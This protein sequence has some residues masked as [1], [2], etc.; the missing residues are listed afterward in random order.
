MN[1][2]IGP[3]VLDDNLPTIVDIIKSFGDKIEVIEDQLFENIDFYKYFPEESCTLALGPTNLIA[4]INRRSNF[5]PG[6]FANFP[7][8]DCTNYY[9]YFA[10]Y[11][12]NSHYMML[13]LGD[14]RNRWYH[15]EEVLECENHGIWLRPNDGSKSFGAFYC[16]E[17]KDL[18]FI[19]RIQDNKLVIISRPKPNIRQE[20]RFFVRKGE[21]I[22]GS[23]YFDKENKY[24]VKTEV[25]L[26]E[27]KDFIRSR[28][29]CQK[30]LDEV[31]WTPD[32][33]F[34]I[35]IGLYGMGDPYIIECNSFSAAGWYGAD[36]NKLLTCLREEAILEW[37]DYFP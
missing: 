17:R 8:Y 1:W 37:K 22:T 14:L 7:N 13:P 26:A 33:V 23:Q 20:Y 25:E 35:D 15:F 6:S 18:A 27:D 2:I 5:V 32:R 36:P 12:L 28:K 9:T 3:S 21:I 24:S 19:D 10:K 11:L 29:F 34:T 16:K 4:Q 31:K 30:I